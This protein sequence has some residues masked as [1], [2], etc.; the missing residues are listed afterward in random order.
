MSPSN[1]M[2]Y[3]VWVIF[4]DRS[5]IKR[6]WGLGFAPFLQLLNK[7]LSL[8]QKIVRIIKDFLYSKLLKNRKKTK[9]SCHLCRDIVCFPPI[10]M[11][12]TEVW[13]IIPQKSEPT[14]NMQVIILLLRQKYGFVDSTAVFLW[15]YGECSGFLA[16]PMQQTEAKWRFTNDRSKRF[17]S[18]WIKVRVRLF[19]SPK[20]M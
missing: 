12:H 14:L 1:E 19:F 9:K 16:S 8:R 4:Y 11:Q 5:K 15:F 13:N 2:D 20:Q 6:C 7:S 3:W 18:L 17:V 10:L